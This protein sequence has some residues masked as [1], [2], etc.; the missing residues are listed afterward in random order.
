M[1]RTTGA[2]WRYLFTAYGVTW[3]F[4][5]PV[6]LATYDLP[7]FSNPYVRSW[8]GDFLKGQ[9]T[10]PAH[11]LVLGGGVLGP[12]LGAVLA[13][14]HRAGRDGLRAL[15]RHLT[16]VRLSDWKGWLTGLLPVLYFGLAA[17]VVFA[18]TGVS[19]TI[20]GGVGA[21]LLALF[22]GALLITGEELGWR[23]TQLP[24]LQERRSAWMASLLVGIAWSYWHLPLML[25]SFL[26]EGAGTA[27]F[28]GAA[29]NA[30]VLYPLMTIPMAV[31]MTFAF[32][33]ARGLVLVTILLHA[34]HNQ[35]NSAMSP[36]PAPTA[37]LEK[38]GSLSGPVLLGVFWLM[39][40]LVLVVFGRQRL[41]RRPKVTASSML[42]GPKPG[43]G[44]RR[45]PGAGGGIFK[46]PGCGLRPYPGYLLTPFCPSFDPSA[47]V[48]VELCNRRSPPESLPIRT[49]SFPRI[50]CSSQSR[51]TACATVV[52]FRHPK[53]T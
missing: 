2:L 6:T 15:R 49:A 13:W 22:A 21:F 3:L 23:G 26:P 42:H 1:E 24:L 27:G 30:L 32:N 34:L 14:R 9:A 40:V 35:L 46:G 39:L 29:A 43:Q 25:M 33:S 10:T 51:A 7:S 36:A 12:L 8:F 53:S 16:D 4:W 45:Y 17:L 52:E 20:G 38:A 5:L 19:V 37:A 41:A 31:M 48:R 44:R 18:L 47:K 11:W 50:A 28:A